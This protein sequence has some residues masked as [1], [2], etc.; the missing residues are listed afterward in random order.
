MKIQI[1]KIKIPASAFLII[2]TVLVAGS[3]LMVLFLSPVQITEKEIYL[4]IGGTVI[5][6]DS[7]Q[8]VVNATLKFYDENGTFIT[9]TKTDINGTYKTTITFASLSNVKIALLKDGY[10][11]AVYDAS[12][13][14]ADEDMT[15]FIVNIDAYKIPDMEKIHTWYWNESTAVFN[16]NSFSY[17]VSSNGSVYFEF[18]T[19][20]KLTSTP[21]RYTD[22]NGTV[23][24]SL[25]ILNISYNLTSVPDNATVNITLFSSNGILFG[26]LNRTG[27]YIYIATPIN[28]IEDAITFGIEVGFSDLN[29]TSVIK[30]DIELYFVADSDLYGNGTLIGDVQSGFV[31]EIKGQ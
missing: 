9:S 18:S 10:Y 2:G 15:Y 31:I 11:P 7:G 19:M 27:T 8:P 20:Y 21:I 23:H 4:P 5:D 17:N 14:V 29:N 28:Q 12:L 3:L 30:F 26:L 22:I 16:S 1:G 13:T 6:V 24:Y 25:A